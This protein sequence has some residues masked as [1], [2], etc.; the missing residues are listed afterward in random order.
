[1]LKPKGK[2]LHKISDP[3]RKRVVSKIEGENFSSFQ[4]LQI[5]QTFSTTFILR[6]H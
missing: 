3:Q 2:I 4:V 1:M 5:S 6:G